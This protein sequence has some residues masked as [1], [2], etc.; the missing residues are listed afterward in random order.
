M[1]IGMILASGLGLRM[2]ECLDLPKQFY[3]LADKPVLIHTV[4]QFERHPQVDAVCVVYL[5][6]WEDYIQECIDKYG[7]QKVRFLVPGGDT[8]QQSTYNGL[9]ALEKH[10]APD[11]IILVHD[12]VRPFITQDIIT[13]NIR[14]ATEYGNAMTAL[15]STDT[16]VCAPDGRSAVAAM[17]R[18]NTFT[19]QTPQTYPLGFGLR[20]YRRAY[21]EGRTNTINCCELFIE[22]GEQVYIVNGR[23]T[24]IKM[25]TEDDIAFLS[26]MHHL[27][28]RE[29]GESRATS[30]SR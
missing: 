18:D 19:V 12:G 25:T 13:D 28:M 16:L 15:R 29:N 14:T 2:G 17:E 9:C 20:H 24:N 22:M 10:C 27:Y 30:P 7:I 11:D 8:R 3:K 6:T 4:E 5:P 21:E 26:T 1:N 23:K